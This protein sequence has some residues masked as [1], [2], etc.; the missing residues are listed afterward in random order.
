[1][2]TVPDN[3]PSSRHGQTLKAILASVSSSRPWFVARWRDGSAGRRSPRQISGLAALGWFWGLVLLTLLGGA[4]L[5]EYLG[6]PAPRTHAGLAAVATEQP[7]LG[8]ATAP[9]DRPGPIAAAT[10][11][12]SRPG[13]SAGPGS[14]DETAE[15]SRRRTPP[16]T[17]AEAAATALPAS[18]PPQA[19]FPAT[20]AVPAA[21]A[22]P[23]LVTAPDAPAPAPAA[24]AEDIA[25]VAPE[26][27]RP[28][29]LPASPLE[30][31]DSRAA[32][33]APRRAAT[34]AAAPEPR[35]DRVAVPHAPRALQA[36]GTRSPEATRRAVF[37]SQ[38]QTDQ[39]AE[40]SPSLDRRCRSVLVRVQL[41]EKPTDADRAYLRAGCRSRD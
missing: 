41:E 8:E 5:L 24:A 17:M 7:A 19:L 38:A 35:L 1:M 36:G 12:E 33:P 27:I 22:R 20:E 13:A 23:G 18:V 39:P 31:E 30:A 29:T 32:V 6:P 25:R 16:L 11:A 40:G 3:K 37:P 15:D 2:N 14:S 4:A 21:A 26:E 28:Q 9:G 34:D 10:P